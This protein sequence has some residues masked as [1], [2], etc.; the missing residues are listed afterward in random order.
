M[1]FDHIKKQ[2]NNHPDSIA[3][4]TSDK[5][6][7]Y[8]QLNRKVALAAQ[9]IYQK[10][11]IEKGTIALYFSMNRVDFIIYF[12]AASSIGWKAVPIDPK[13]PSAAVKEILSDSETDLLITDFDHETLIDIWEGEQITS[14]DDIDLN[15]QIQLPQPHPASIF[16][17]GYTSGTSGK[18]KGFVRTQ[19]SWTESFKNTDAE[20]QVRP[21]DEVIITGSLAHSLFLYGAIHALAS[22]A[23]I[24][25]IEQF[26]A[27]KVARNVQNTARTFLYVVPTMLESLLNE[28][29]KQWEAVDCIIS[30]GAKWNH[31]R[32]AKVEKMFVNANCIEFYGASELSFV[33]ILHHSY[34]VEKADSVG[35]PFAG[36]SLT[37]RDQHFQEVEP[38]EIGKLY[39]K[40]DM[41]FKE[42]WN[43]PNETEKVIKDGWVTV[44][45]LARI[46]EDGFVY[47]VGRANQ[48]IISGGL[49]IY[50]EEVERT[51]QSVRSVEE[52]AV[53]GLPDTYW[54]EKVVA[55]IKWRKGNEDDVRSLEHS[56]AKSLAKYKWPKA[57]ITVKDFP[58]TVS[59]KIAR[60][61]LID[62]Y[63]SGG[64]KDE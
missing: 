20:Y 2:A 46:D 45:D 42:Y 41:V 49:N 28:K 51:I 8:G 54:G 39:V 10:V 11:P 13:V 5:T 31:S 40:S 4:T 53:V 6:W 50:P 23:T 48:M 60:K 35:R 9:H 27:A 63:M 32:R 21:D 59:E 47:L 36:V 29:A 37:I 3:I 12:L 14:S 38:G 34:A 56:C 17:L 44:G 58:Y 52:C 57:Y 33:S 55:F 26:S 16:Y 22:G 62:Q 7:T 64:M 30:S 61:K 1:I 19:R 24:R 18:P 43:L 15:D 25:L